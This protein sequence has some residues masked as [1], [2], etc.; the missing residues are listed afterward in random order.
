MSVLFH[1]VS[2]F[3]CGLYTCAGAPD[4]C[5]PN[6]GGIGGGNWR[7]PRDMR[8]DNSEYQYMLKNSRKQHYMR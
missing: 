4:T 3:I 1:L 2:S 7:Y 8:L 6:Y 5:G